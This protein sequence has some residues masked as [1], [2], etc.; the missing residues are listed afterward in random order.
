VIYCWVNVQKV[1]G[2]NRNWVSG[3]IAWSKQMHGP[4]LNGDV[5]M[6]CTIPR[7][8]KSCK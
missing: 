2:A 8:R 4:R 7:D 3:I 1:S 5:F 6:S